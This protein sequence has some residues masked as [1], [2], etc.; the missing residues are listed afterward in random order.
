MPSWLNDIPHQLLCHFTIK[1]NPDQQDPGKKTETVF[2]GATLEVDYKAESDNIRVILS[3]R[4]PG[5]TEDE[6]AMLTTKF[7]RGSKTSGSGIDGGG[8]TAEI[9]IMKV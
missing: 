3:D 8:F 7:Y 1:Q 2:A 6:L 9:V 4:G 5:I